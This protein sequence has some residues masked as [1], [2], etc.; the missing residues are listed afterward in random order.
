M[1]TTAAEEKR[2]ADY[3]QAEADQLRREREYADRPLQKVTLQ[4]LYDALERETISDIA[5]INLDIGVLL[6]CGEKFKGDIEQRV[7]MLVRILRWRIEENYGD[8]ERW[9]KE[10][11]GRV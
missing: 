2:V 3:D 6:K 4:P 9:R 10:K 5:E 1:L 8:I 7:E 11:S